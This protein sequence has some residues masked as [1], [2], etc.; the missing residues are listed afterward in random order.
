MHGKTAPVFHKGE[1]L[2]R[3]LPDP[4]T[5]TRYHSLVTDPSELP[6]ELMVEAWS[7][8]EEFGEEVQALRHASF[9]IWGVQFHPESLFSDG[10]RRLLENF[11]S[12]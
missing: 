1:G 5:V 8:T 3:G 7:D 9:P 4:L 12:L 10:G 2:F 6:D 11:L